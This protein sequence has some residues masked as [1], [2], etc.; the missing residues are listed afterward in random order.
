MT[1]IIT[2]HKVRKKLDLFT[3]KK[4]ILKYF[5]TESNICSPVLLNLLNLLQ[6][7]DKILGKPPIWSLF[8]NSF[9]KFNKEWANHDSCKIL[10]ILLIKLTLCMLDNFLCFCCHLLLTFF[11][12]LTFS[13]KNLSGT[14]SECQTVWIQI[15]NNIWLVLVWVRI[16][17]TGYQL[18]IKVATSKERFNNCIP[19]CHNQLNVRT[20]HTRE[21]HNKVPPSVTK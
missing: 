3:P 1:S 16:I 2:L 20:E 13:K 4:A 17:C 10:C 19:A 8:L 6:K 7:I 5:L 12:K 14:L 11:S 15:N 18:M 9:N 21:F